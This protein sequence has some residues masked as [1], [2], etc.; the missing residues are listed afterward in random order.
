MLTLKGLGGGWAGTHI[1]EVLHANKKACI[2]WVMCDKI[3]TFPDSAC[4]FIDE[5]KNY[6]PVGVLKWNTE[7]KYRIANNVLLTVE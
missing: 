6:K 4:F 3:D 5:M 2:F 1:Q 7:K